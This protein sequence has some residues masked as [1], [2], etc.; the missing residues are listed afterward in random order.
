MVWCFNWKA[1][2]QQ[3]WFLIIRLSLT[4]WETLLKRNF[5][6]RQTQWQWQRQRPFRKHY[7][8]VHDEKTSETQI[9][10]L[11]LMVTVT[12]PSFRKQWHGTAL[13]IL[14]KFFYPSLKQG[15]RW[16]DRQC[17]KTQLAHFEFMS[18]CQL[19]HFRSRYS[20]FCKLTITFIRKSCNRS[21]DNN[22]ENNTHWQFF[23][24]RERGQIRSGDPDKRWLAKMT[25]P[26]PGTLWS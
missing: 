4:H 18:I 21:K 25:K 17:T 6:Q 3:L 14:V 23:Q 13:A 8:R 2:D 9:T 1:P 20:V 11:T 24:N 12:D 5:W 16:T 26:G 19:E 10:I 7:Q 15:G 22:M